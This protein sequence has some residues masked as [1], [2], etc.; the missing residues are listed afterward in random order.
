ME[1]SANRCPKCGGSGSV[2]L[3]HRSGTAYIPKMATVLTLIQ[4]ILERKE[5]AVVFSAFNDPLDNLPRWLT[6]AGVCHV[7]LGWPSQ[8]EAP[9]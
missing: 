4:E 9:G 1:P 5:Q 8:P 3:P 2:P 7:T 6:E